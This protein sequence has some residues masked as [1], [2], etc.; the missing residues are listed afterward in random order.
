MHLFDLTVQRLLCQQRRY[1]DHH[2]HG[3]ER[4]YLECVD[5]GI[6]GH[7]LIWYERDGQ[8]HRDVLGGGQHGIS[9]DSCLYSGG[10]DILH[11]PGSGD[12]DHHL[13]AH[14]RHGRNGLGDHHIE[15]V[16]DGVRVGHRGD[17]HGR[18]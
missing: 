12:I 15:P 7:D 2:G 17:H 3:R 14:T 13:H 4:L 18:A 10:T 9:K 11:F 16:R 8:W 1:G 6:L 5:G